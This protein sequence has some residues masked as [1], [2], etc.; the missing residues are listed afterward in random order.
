MGYDAI[1]HDGTGH[2]MLMP[3]LLVASI[4]VPVLAA[5]SVIPTSSSVAAG[6]AVLTLVVGDTIVTL[7]HPRGVVE[8]YILVATVLMACVVTGFGLVV[9]ALPLMAAPAVT[10]VVW[11][12]L[13]EPGGVSWFTSV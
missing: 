11:G 10:S 6:Y 9:P 2:G 3:G 5:L 12:S 4:I 7:P 8:G 13:L 1:P